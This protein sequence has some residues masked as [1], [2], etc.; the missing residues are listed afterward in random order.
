M[1]REL[2][3][4][5][6]GLLGFK[7]QFTQARRE[8]RDRLADYFATIA[9]T[10]EEVAQSFRD[11]NIPHGKCAEMLGHADMLEATV[12][13][14]LGANEAKAYAEKLKAAHEVE[15]LA[16]EILGTSDPEPQIQQLDAAAGT[17]RALSAAI[18]AA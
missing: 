5:A 15:L 9:K 10:I 7:D 12:T 6:K 13:P 18:R 11:G 14:E 4:V 1:L 8:R 3:D 17:L 2:L 16:N